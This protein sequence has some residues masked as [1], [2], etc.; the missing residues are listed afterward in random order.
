M[1][2]DMKIIQSTRGGQKLCLQGYMYTKQYCRKESIRWVCVKRNDGCKGSLMTKVDMK[3]PRESKDHDHPRDRV[4]IEVTKARQQM[5]ERA[6]QTREMPM[7]IHSEIISSINDPDVQSQ[8]PQA[9]TCK[10]VL[11]R[12]RNK[13]YPKDPSSHEDLEFVGPW[14][15]TKE[16]GERFLLHDN[17]STTD[18]IVIFSTDTGLRKLSESKI[19]FMDGNFQMAPALFEQLYVIHVPLGESSIAVVYAFLQ[20]KTKGTYCSLLDTLCEEAE[21]KG[22]FPFPDTVVIDFELAVHNAIQSM[23]DGAQI[24][25]CYYHLSQCVWRKIQNLGLSTLYRDDENFRLFC[26]KLNAL[27]F[28]PIAEVEEGYNHLREIAPVEATELVDYF[29][30][31]F[32]YSYKKIRAAGGLCRFKRCAP[33]YAPGTWNVNSTTLN[34]GDR[35]N[36]LSEAWNNKFRILVGTKH[37]SIWRAVECLQQENSATEVLLSQTDAGNPPKKRIKRKYVQLQ[38][39][40]KNLCE[41]HRDG[42]SNV[43]DFLRRVGRHLRS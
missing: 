12:V 16:D 36:N 38:E 8:L 34:D 9:S 5:K 14:A 25:G 31:T 19:W 22:H 13:K 23:F 26:G 32:V 27:A 21:A 28:L 4:E 33:Q 1:Q 41:Q 43:N 37:P 17:K 20:R 40:L 15:L 24:N 35:T 29:G 30:S 11:Q 10:K 2:D 7:Q 3:D 42:Q 6:E 39:R 18:R